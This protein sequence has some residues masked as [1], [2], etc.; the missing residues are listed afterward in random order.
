MQSKQSLTRLS[1]ADLQPAAQNWSWY[2]YFSFWM[3]DVHSLGGYVVAASLFTLGLASWQVLLALVT[4]IIIVQYC[5]NLVAKP[6]QHAGVPWSVVCR[7]AFGVYGA[8]IPAVIRGLIAM[9]WYGIQTWLA[10]NALM[11]V[12]L[13]YVPSSILWTEYAFA[14]LSLLGWA[15]FIFMW[16]LQALVFWKGM[17]TI[18]RF[19]DWAGPAVY[20]VMFS[21]VVWLIAQVGWSN[22]SL[23]LSRQILT[24]S[25]QLWQFWV[26][27]A[28]IVSYF[29]GPLL[30]FGDFARYGKNMQQVKKGN[31]WGL[32]FNFIFFALITVIIIAATY[33]LTGNIV[34]DPLATVAL[35]DHD[36]A[37]V[38]AVI[39][40]LTATIGINIVANFVSA[41]FDFSNVWPQKISFR[42][43]GLIAAVASIFI[44][45]WNLFQSPELI[46]YTLD[47]LAAFI[48]PLFGI[49]IADYYWVNKQQMNT[50]DLFSEDPRGAYWYNRG[51]NP[52]ALLA[53]FL[54][55][56]IGLLFVL[57]PALKHLAAFNW[58]IGVFCGL[59]FYGLLNLEKI[60]QPHTTITP[61]RSVSMFS[62]LTKNK[63][64]LMIRIP[65][66]QKHNNLVS[67]LLSKSQ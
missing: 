14:G 47:V 6:S 46:H 5:A 20:V 49:L 31:F 59:A 32:P 4:G 52:K 42:R 7:Q 18:K 1:N 67:K 17:Q 50:D 21:L 11:I 62:P 24:P 66:T 63:S 15:C 23:R 60:R 45:P 65:L 51:F 10:S 33:R 2:N 38:L 54:A 9:A 36:L 22:I 55:V 12:I 19:I 13:K 26:A 37:I 3:S 53:L 40:I 41:G 35:I 25:E 16:L 8:N 39:T 56:S 58:F 48:G 43:G 29:S 64:K 28:L 57:I 34:N 30:N 61:Q 27:V 44:T